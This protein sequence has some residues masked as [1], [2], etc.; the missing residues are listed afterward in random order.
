MKKLC[1]VEEV[2]NLSSL[3]DRPLHVLPGGTH[4]N[5]LDFGILHFTSSNY[6]GYIRDKPLR[7]FLSS[8]S[9]PTV[10]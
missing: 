6:R 4:P 3:M 5:A 9:T 1:M 2:R 10:R 7:L 8:S